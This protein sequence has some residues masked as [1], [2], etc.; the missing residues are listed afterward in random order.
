MVSFDIFRIR[1]VTGANVCAF[2]LG[3]VV[4]SNFF[5][6]TLVRAAGARLLGSQDRPDVPGNG[7]D[8]G[9]G[10]SHLAGRS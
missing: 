6:L 1:T 3:A 8:G 4:F 9:A 7:R 5:L 10:R 2:F